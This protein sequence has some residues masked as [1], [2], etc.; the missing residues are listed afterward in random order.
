MHRTLIP[1]IEN[2]RTLQQNTRV[3]PNYP[4][5]LERQFT[6]NLHIKIYGYLNKPTIHSKQKVILLIHSSTPRQSSIQEVRLSTLTFMPLIKVWLQLHSYICHTTTLNNVLKF[7]TDIDKSPKTCANIHT[8]KQNK[9]AAFST[10]KK[11]KRKRSL[12]YLLAWSQIP[13]EQQASGREKKEQ[14]ALKKKFQF[15]PG[16]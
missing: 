11:E 9:N 10:K 3:I 6:T 4:Q 12:A 16:R 1:K 8:R 7:R 15:I 5:A 13:Q 14:K 2:Y